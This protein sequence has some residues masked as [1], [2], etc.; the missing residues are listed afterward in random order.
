M[1]RGAHLAEAG[2]DKGLRDGGEGAEDGHGKVHDLFHYCV[3]RQ[4]HR[5]QRCTTQFTFELP[6]ARST[7]SHLSA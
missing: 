6:L 3:R 2:G 4:R 7:M 1:L 5:T